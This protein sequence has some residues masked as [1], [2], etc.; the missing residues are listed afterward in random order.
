MWS[1]ENLRPHQIARPLAAC[2][3]A[4]HDFQQGVPPAEFP[5]DDG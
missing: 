4:W 3:G 5:A 2:A 1:F